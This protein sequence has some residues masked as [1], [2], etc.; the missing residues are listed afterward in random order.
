MQVIQAIKLR[1]PR[2]YLRQHAR[3]IVEREREGDK[4]GQCLPVA[5][6]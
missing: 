2:K 4:T 6:L 1:T 3:G 5:D